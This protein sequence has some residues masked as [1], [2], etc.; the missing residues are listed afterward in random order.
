M[1]RLAAFAAGSAAAVAAG[2]ILLPQAAG[3][4]P[5]DGLVIAC[6]DGR[7]LTRSNG[8]SWWEIDS[9]ITKELTGSVYTSRRIRVTYNG[10][11]VHDKTYGAH[12]GQPATTCTGPELLDGTNDPI[13]GS[14]WD[15][16]LSGT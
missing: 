9:P 4:A 12:T 8:V 2:W 1:K 15:I 5:Q 7:Y 3:G 10:E 6:S 13:P 11:I 14:L 16:D